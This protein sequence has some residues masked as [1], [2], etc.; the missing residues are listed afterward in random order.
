MSVI[1][2]ALVTAA[3]AA[4]A[5]D[6]LV[7][8]VWT[9]VSEN[10]LQHEDPCPAQ[11]CSY[12]AVE[13]ISGVMN[14]WCGGAFASGYG[15]LGGLVAWGGG[16]NGYFGSE[17][18]VFDLATG[19][20]NRVSEPYDNGGASVAPDCSP[21]GV[22]P[23]GSACP[24]HT[25]DQIDYHP[26]TN[27]L[28]IL[29]GTPDPVCGGCVDDR[30][31]FFDFTTGTWSLGVR[32]SS[33]LYYG[34]TTAY[35][36]LRDRYWLLSGYVHTLSS[37]DPTE[38][39][40]REHGAPYPGDNEI[41][42]AGAID[43]LRDLYLFIDASGDGQVYALPLAGPFDVWVPLTTSGDTDIQQFPALGFE[44]EPLCE[45]FVAWGSG[46][47]LFA[48]TPPASGDPLTAE[49]VWT[50]VPPDPSN[51]VIPDRNRNGT[52]S[53]FRY[54]PSVNAL[55]LVSHTDGPVWAYRFTANPDPV[56]PPPPTTG[57]AE[58]GTESTTDPPAPGDVAPDAVS[59]AAGCGCAAG[60]R[61][62]GWLLAAAALLSARRRVRPMGETDV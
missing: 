25:Y 59:A 52:Y 13:G 41:D 6:D 57:G 27:R 51:T 9:V 20:W 12:S 62:S 60:G 44:W 22:Y 30:V 61:G 37:Y 46:A 21:D 26:A 36:A 2:L 56:A 35:D 7:P 40:W 14:D 5:W 43:P 33:A 48:L 24:T 55:L 8:G 18:Y 29:G 3:D 42:G 11:D 58:T 53:R 47:D 45:C 28:V 54:A 34:G 39:H 50:R 31:H 1:H 10:T 49:W 38:D 32:K 17:V 16:H 19:R 4:P 15:D 23:D